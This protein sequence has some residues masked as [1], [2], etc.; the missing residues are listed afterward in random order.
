MTTTAIRPGE[1]GFIMASPLGN[2]EVVMRGEA[3]AGIRYSR[4]RRRGGLA[5]RAARGI[6]YQLRRYF[7]D[8][9]RCFDLKLAPCG[10]PFQRRVWR[11][12]RRIP[13]GA[14]MT[15]GEIARRLASGPR[16]VGGAC[17][18]NPTP[19]VI[20]CHRVVAAGAPGGY[21]GSMKGRMLHA[22]RWLLQHEHSREDRR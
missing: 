10:T 2:L 6:E 17:R 12:L 14:T 20:P 9:R 21:C 22:K 18:R 16:A 11:L 4:G 15:Y 19:I 3:L 1:P 7:D 5:G 8:P 13:P